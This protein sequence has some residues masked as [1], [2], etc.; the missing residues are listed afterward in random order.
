MELFA[1]ITPSEFPTGLMMFALGVVSGVIATAS[2]Y[3]V[4][5]SR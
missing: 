3:V 5:R 1:H 4:R 2:L